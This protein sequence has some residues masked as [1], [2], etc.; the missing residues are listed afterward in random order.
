MKKLSEAAWDQAEAYLYRGSGRCLIFHLRTPGGLYCCCGVQGGG[1]MGFSHRR[2]WRQQWTLPQGG[3]RTQ[4][5]A[6]TKGLAQRGPI[7]PTMI[8]FGRS[9]CRRSSSLAWCSARA[10]RPQRGRRPSSLAEG[11]RASDDSIGSK[12]AL[13]LYTLYCFCVDDIKTRPRYAVSALNTSSTPYLGLS[14][15]VIDSPGT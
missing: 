11:A 3:A 6:S 7:R 2:P 12:P 5:L 15:L 8:R 10:W 14:S 4:G 9:A 1:S 13:C